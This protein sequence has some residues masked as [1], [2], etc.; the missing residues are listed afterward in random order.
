MQLLAVC[1][2]G[3]FRWFRPW[4]KDISSD[5]KEA[6]VDERQFEKAIR[7]FSNSEED[8][9]QQ[10]N[11]TTLCTPDSQKIYPKIRLMLREA[12]KKKTNPRAT[13]QPLQAS[14]SMLNIKGNDSSIRKCWYGVFG[15]LFW[16]KVLLETAVE[17]LDQKAP[18]YRMFGK[19]Q[20][21][22]ISA[23]TS[24]Q[25][26]ELVLQPRDLGTAQPLPINSSA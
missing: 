26:S 14:V 17:L 12:V 20:T 16:N 11:L 3:V 21:Q 4:S 23:N 8:Y 13:S 25:L 7:Q 2:S 1:W 24:K 15:K 18:W 19:H 9:S 10:A 22:H 6:A 5:L